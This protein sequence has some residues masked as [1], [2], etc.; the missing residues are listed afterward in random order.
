MSY[1]YRA[2]C[3]VQIIASRGHF[4]DNTYEQRDVRIPYTGYG[5]EQHGQRWLDRGFERVA[6][7]VRSKSTGRVVTDVTYTNQGIQS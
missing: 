3:S 7:I 1:D 2:P 5:T 4:K 6:V